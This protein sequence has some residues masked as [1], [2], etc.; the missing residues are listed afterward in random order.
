MSS[1]VGESGV[2]GEVGESGVSGEV[3]ESGVSGDVSENRGIRQ[4]RTPITIGLATKES[5]L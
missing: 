1:E 4:D 3:G 2:S 5:G